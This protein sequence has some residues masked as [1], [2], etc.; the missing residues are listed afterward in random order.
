M[1]A[2][3]LCLTLAACDT[4]TATIEDLS[5]PED[6]TVTNRPDRV[7]QLS[8]K[9][10]QECIQACTTLNLNTCVPACIAQLSSAAH[11]FFDPLQAC[12]GPACTMVDGGP[13]P[14]VDPGSQA[15]GD[16]VM[17]NCTAQEAAC[18]AN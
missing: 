1:R 12:S 10:A 14:C 3:C 2:L 17:Q 8:C 11:T 13:G 18:V 9:E 16:C 15:C 4:T 5:V 7:L 6:L